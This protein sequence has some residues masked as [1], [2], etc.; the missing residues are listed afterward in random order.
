MK[1]INEADGNY[2]AAVEFDLM[3]YKLANDALGVALW[4]MEIVCAAP[5]SPDNKITWS[6]EV[7]QLLGFYKEQDFPNVLSSLI[8]RIHSE[9]RA[10][11]VV[12][13]AAHLDDH[14]GKTPFDIKYRV[15]H[16][17]GE[18]IHVH[19]FGT[20]QRD[21]AGVPLRVA[22]ALMDV[23]KTKEMEKSVR[24]EKERTMLMLD[25]SPL[26]TQIW[27]RNLNTIDC[28]E[29]CVRLYGFRDKREYADRFIREC[30]PEYQ[31]D[32]RRSDEKA[33]FF[34]NKA[35]EEGYC[36]FEWMHR[37]PQDDT[38][39]PAEITLVR[40]K[41]GDDDV[42]LGYTRDLRE[43][44]KMIEAVEYQDNLMRAVNQAA[45]FLL[46]SDVDVFEKTLYQSMKIIANAVN[47]DCMYIWK[48][49]E[50]DGRLHCSQLFEWAE[51]RTIYSENE[52]LHRYSETFP[53]WEGPRKC[54]L[55][56]HLLGY[57]PFL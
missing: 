23:T 1:S 48:N 22:G 54:K 24:A 14:T 20:S 46:N 35:F 36:F 7:R 34:V 56:Y 26:C 40:A 13:F 11:A 29:A 38:L 27:D 9:E 17:N 49:H 55:L 2:L 30:S 42:V 18:Y 21:G 37:I 47:A 39:I 3:K 10:A 51:Q 52:T 4:D 28:N 6:Q 5:I 44:Y 25:A 33:V 53:G 50:I 16:K 41:Y 8:G 57:S 15:M 31:P 12:A 45:I 43:H 19:A 32:G